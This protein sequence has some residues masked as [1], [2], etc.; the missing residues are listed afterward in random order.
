MTGALRATTLLLLSLLLAV[1]AGTDGLGLPAVDVLIELRLPR[2]LLAVVAGSTLA[3]SGVGCQALL[4]NTLAEPYVL[5]VSGGAALGGVLGALLVGWLGGPVW[6]ASGF[7]VVGAMVAAGLVLA[8]GDRAYSQGELLL[9]GVVF[10]AF[11]A[12]VVTVVKTLVSASQAQEIL[13][14]LMGQLA[15][16]DP[17]LLSLTA[18]ASLVSFVGL[19]RQA[20]A[21]DALALGDKTAHS[22]GVDI[23]R[24]R[25][26]TYL[27]L[28]FGVGVLVS[29]VGL[30]GFV[31]LL[32]PHLVRRG[33][34][35]RHQPLMLQSGVLGASLLLVS[36][37]ICR[38][39]FVLFATELP[40]G[41]L[42]A[43]L[44]APFFVW[45]LRRNE[46]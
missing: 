12:A 28:S 17:V 2:L 39:G 33:G 46:S 43:F 25:R 29:V 38:L 10:N 7:A 36:D 42:T 30:I 41:V 9:Q 45:K 37:A 24:T 6:L 44:G 35:E 34:V 4:R 23:E 21:L 22:L 18:A 1:F 15:I 16:Y 19:W 27:S 32:V 11:A 3:V 5:G 26:S 20:R 31:G 14:W 40:V 8:R 13:Y